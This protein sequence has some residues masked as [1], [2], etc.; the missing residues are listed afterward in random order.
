MTTLQGS[1]DGIRD[2]PA[3]MARLKDEGLYRRRPFFYATHFT[4]WMTGVAAACGLLLAFDHALIQLAGAVLF[5]VSQVQLGFLMHDLG[6][7]QVFKSQR[8]N[9]WVSSVMSAAMLGM[10]NGWWCHKHNQHHAEPNHVDLDPDLDIPLLAFSPEDAASARG[11]RRLV[12]RYQSL[13]FL[14]MLCFAGYGMRINS[15][16]QVLSRRKKMDWVEFALILLHL[17]TYAAIILWTG[18]IWVGLLAA[19]IHQSILGVYLGLSFATN[20]KGMELIDGES[21]LSFFEKQ[22]VTTRNLKPNWLTDFTFGALGVQIE[23][24]LFPHMPRP[25]LR[26]ASRAV[27]EWC[28]KHD[29]P[30]HETGFFRGIGEVLAHL[31]EIS[32]AAVRQRTAIAL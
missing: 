17:S 13:L 23:H 26:R 22:I 7:N 19:F 15:I 20:H 9:Q 14:P 25:S 21:K 27:R 5:A 6:H 31:H 28:H 1:S 4:V 16:K 30:Y 24:H 32:R 12:V 8:T 29:L 18:A 11:I 10:S 2:F 3:L